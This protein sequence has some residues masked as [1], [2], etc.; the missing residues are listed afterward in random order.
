I[1]TPA[2]VLF[3]WRRWKETRLEVG[4]HRRTEEA[5]RILN[6]ELDQRVQQRTAELVKVNEN[7]RAE[8]AERE[9][10]EGAL[11]V[12]EQHLRQ[13]HKME[14][15]AMKLQPGN[16]ED[17]KLLRASIPATIEICADIPADAPAVLADSTQIHQII[18]NLGTNA[19]HAMS[20]RPG[21]LR[22]NLA[23]VAVDEVL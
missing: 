8:I 11:K 19:A 22:V 1:L 5:L 6:A 21:Q 17:L 7:L 23:T 14:R 13:S 15:K 12:S 9:R 20:G 10:A 2:I 3:A 16:Q 4:K 18:M